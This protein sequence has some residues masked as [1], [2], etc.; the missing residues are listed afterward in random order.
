M[1]AAIL[2][3]G[4]TAIRDSLKTLISHIGVSTDSTAFSATQTELN[5]GGGTNLI[6]ASSETNVDD[7]TFD[8]QISIDG[9]T[10]FTGNSIRTIGALDGSAAGDALTRTVRSAIGVEAGDLFTIGLRFQ[11]QD[12]S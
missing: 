7:F 4:K 5:P 8:A 9:D 10:E 11:V 2:N 1:A 6:K 12:N 3:Q